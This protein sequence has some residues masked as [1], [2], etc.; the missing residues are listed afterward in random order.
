MLV[1][2]RQGLISFC[3]RLPC[4]SSPGLIDL[5]STCGS[6]LEVTVLKLVTSP[7]FYVLSTD[8]LFITRSLFPHN[9]RMMTP[10]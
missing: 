3:D 9:S 10:F 4:N 1:P 7:F 2:F 8:F 5:T 6:S